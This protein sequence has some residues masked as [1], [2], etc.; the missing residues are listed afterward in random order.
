MRRS[1]TPWRAPVPPPRLGWRDLVA[2][3]GAGLT[4][5]PG[6]SVLT[7]LGTVLGVGA[8]VAILGLTA[9]ASGQIGKQFNSLTATTVTVTAVDGQAGPDLAAG[10]GTDGAAV[11]TIPA[12]SDR[13]VRRLNGVVTAGTW[14]Q[15]RF[16]A[17]PL[18]SASPIVRP[19]SEAD[20][21]GIVPVFAASAGTLGAAE[22]T[23][24]QGVPFNAFH[25]G[26]AEPVAML[27]ATAA[28]RLGISRLDAGPAVFINNRA[29][30]VIGIIGDTEQ[31]P[32]LVA[33]VVVPRQTARRVFGPPPVDGQ[34]QMIIRTRLGAAEV[35]A[36]LAPRA[37]RP[38]RPDLLTAIPPPAPKVLRG[39]VTDELTGLFLLLATICL[40]IGAIGIANTTIVAVFERTGEI[41]LRRA[42]GAR[43]RH[44]AVQFLV[45][46]TAL[47]LLGGLIG[48][49]LAI[50][51][52]VAV[53]LAKQ[54]TAV[55]EPVSVFP[56]PLIGAAV[57]LLAGMYPAMRAARIEPQE[58]L[59]Q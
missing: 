47:G 45:E 31:L 33:G 57:G 50:I 7:M 13:R 29:F 39:K 51:T 18:I 30:T 40:V 9:T 10:G 28:K 32:E 48:T 4:Q 37:L 27:G 38:D 36:G 26:R 14:R 6:R 55:L 20:M 8:F 25:E 54:W 23:I 11:E 53:A 22:A 24:S 2:E 16:G 12:D 19:G 41:G 59:R 58:A 52:V 5:R 34:G 42:L 1:R 35:I 49:A 3:A 43:P 17:D 44:I 56:A 46:S 15:I 21:G